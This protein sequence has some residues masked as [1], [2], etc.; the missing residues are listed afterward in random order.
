[1]EEFANVCAPSSGQTAQRKPVSSSSS[2]R[3]N[4]G[5]CATTA[6]LS[7]LSVAHRS[8]NPAPAAHEAIKS[9]DGQQNSAA[10]I[11]S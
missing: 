4:N 3:R 11:E 10:A 8:G 6:N 7:L 2:C 1:M 5:H 9:F